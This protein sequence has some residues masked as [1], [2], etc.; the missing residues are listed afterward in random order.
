MRKKLATTT[1]VA[2]LITSIGAIGEVNAN[3]KHTPSSSINRNIELAKLK[4]FS[5][6]EEGVDAGESHFLVEEKSKDGKSIRRFET[7]VIY[8]KLVASRRTLKDHP[9]A[10]NSYYM[11]DSYTFSTNQTINTSVT[12]NAGYGPFTVSVGKI[13]SSGYVINVPGGKSVKSKPTIRGDVY[14]VKT[15]T[16]EISSSGSVIG[17]SY[18]TF[19][20]ARNVQGWYRLL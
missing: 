8:D 15:R 2:T 9:D 1:A 5:S 16:D 18:K 3:E 19:N 12:F 14:E 20:R 7:T 11:V 10:K 17:T 4:T 6:V 13:A